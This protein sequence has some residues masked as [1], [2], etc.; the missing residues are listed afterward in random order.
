MR[1]NDKS[2]G[3]FWNKNGINFLNERFNYDFMVKYDSIQFIFVGKLTFILS[4]ILSPKICFLSILNHIYRNE[5]R[6]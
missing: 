1:I 3:I 2:D 5:I 6:I 4:I